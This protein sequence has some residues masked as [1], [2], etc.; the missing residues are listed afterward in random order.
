MKR[1]QG[2]GCGLCFSPV[3]GQ[4]MPMCIKLCNLQNEYIKK[5]IAGVH[6][7]ETILRKAWGWAPEHLKIDIISSNTV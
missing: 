4:K 1:P 2:A 3:W 5:V 6:Q 7:D